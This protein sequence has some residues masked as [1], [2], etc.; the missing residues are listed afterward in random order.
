MDFKN[1]KL[2]DCNHFSGYKPC[3]PGHDC[4]TQGCKMELDGEKT[5]LTG[6]KILIIS[7]DALGNVLLNTSIL[8]SLKRKYPV[9]TVHWITM[10]SALPIL[11]NNEFIDKVYVWDETDKMIISEMKY[12]VL[13]NGDKSDYACAFAGIVKADEKYGFVL[14]ENGK[15]I[16]ASESAMYNYSMGVNDEL[17]FRK[18]LKSGSQ[19]IH[20]TF[21]LEYKEYEYV[22]NFSKSETEFIEKYKEQIGYDANNLYIGFNTGCS[23]LFPNKKMTVEQ[24][25]SLINDLAQTDGFKILLL[26]GKEDTERNLKI[27]ES[28]DKEIQSKVIYTPTN[29]GIRNGACFMEVCDVVITGDSFGMHLAIALKKYVIAWFGLSC[30]NEIELFNRGEKLIPTGLECAPCWNKVC[31]YNLECIEMID[32]QKIAGYVRKYALVKPSFTN[33]N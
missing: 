9:S 1:L 31:P 12:D 28:L 5:H 29:L 25:T 32:L 17:K 24:H 16:P 14:N 26:G 3:F 30:W 7:L 15:I 4:L 11:A 13:L 8:R 10:K 23:N 18:N 19:I 20:E 6:K 22:F 33:K 27:H 2:P 21:D